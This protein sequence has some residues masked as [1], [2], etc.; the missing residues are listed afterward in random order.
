LNKAAV[1]FKSGSLFHCKPEPGFTCRAYAGNELNLMH[2]VAVIESGE[3]VY[4]VTMMSNVLRLNS[5]VEHQKVATDVERLLQ[6][7][8]AA[9]KPTAESSSR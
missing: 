7:R 8:P 2:S 3:K 4:L 9:E 6:A 5:A 1:F